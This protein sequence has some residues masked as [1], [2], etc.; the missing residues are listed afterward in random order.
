MTE[1]GLF[2]W[3]NKPSII[4]FPID[5]ETFRTD[6][7]LKPPQ[8][9]RTSFR[10]VELLAINFVYFTRFACFNDSV[11]CQVQTAFVVKN[12][13]VLIDFIR[14]WVSHHKFMH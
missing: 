12:T 10:A 3:Q 4:D 14:V 6:K 11:A 7:T 1:S 13:L 5:F 2:I 8:H 9:Q